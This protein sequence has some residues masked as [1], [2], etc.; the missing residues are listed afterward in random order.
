[1]PYRRKDS[2]VWWASYVDAS[3]QRVRRAT[4]TTERKEAQALE[5]KWKLEAFRTEQWGEEPSR[6]FAELMVPYLK[7]TLTEK[8]S[9]ERDHYIVSRL[10]ECFGG[11]DLRTLSPKDIR[12]YIEHRQASDIGPATINRELGL[13]SAALNWAKRHLEWQLPNPVTGRLLR[14]PAGRLRWLSREDASRLVMV[15]EKQK[16]APH[17]V[18]FL[19]IALH[20]GMRRG[21]IL[22]LEW[23]RV[24]LS[25]GLVYFQGEHQKNGKLGSVPLN[26]TA[27]AAMQRLQAFRNKHCPTSEWVFAH[28]DGSQIQSVKRAFATACR[29]AGIK[30]FRIHDLRHCCAAWLVQSGVSIRAVAELLRHADIRVTMRYAHLSPETVRAAVS[31]LDTGSRFGHVVSLGQR[32]Q[33]GNALN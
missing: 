19:E 23:R 32:E 10:R 25:A 13:L 2:A 1:M 29:V 8:R 6:T 3:G 30:D 18:E 20:T 26:D 28:R 4:G 17:L 27:K 22:G 33:G 7:A 31:V 11:K 5:S 15:A 24:D 14:A 9:P 12:A 21:E 16:R